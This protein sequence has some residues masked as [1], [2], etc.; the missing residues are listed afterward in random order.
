M[1]YKALIV[2][3]I[4]YFTG[5]S[6][7]AQDKSDRYH[8]FGSVKR[9]HI[10]TYFGPLVA[11][12]N[13][14]NAFSIDLG[15]TAGIFIRKKF[16][17]GLYGQKLITGPPRNDLASIG[18]PTFT[19]GEIDMIHGGGVLGYI[20]KP[21]EVIHW[22]VSGSAGLGILYLYAQDPGTQ[23]REKLYDDR[24]YIAIPKLFIE[25]NMTSW[26]KVNVSAGYRVVGKVN[27]VY[28]NPAGE[29]I[30]T[31]DKA[32][33]TKPEFSISVLFGTYGYG[34]SLLD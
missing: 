4:I 8:E 3:V 1:G 19:D 11:F 32:D 14:E 34:K 21:G 24:I 13:V 26:L 23:S 9:F 17:M 25:T 18:Y 28:T 10:K 15:A 33:Y 6:L 16:Y 7:S 5:L 31:F 12:S 27:G 22:G 29:A 20:H 2:F 30:P